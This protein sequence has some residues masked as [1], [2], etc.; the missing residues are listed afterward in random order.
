[1]SA[2]TLD[3]EWLKTDGLGGFASAAVSLPCSRRYHALLMRAGDRPSLLVNRLDAC[4]TTGGS[5]HAHQRAAVSAGSHRAR[6]RLARAIVHAQAMAGVDVGAAGRPDPASG[7]LRV[8]WADRDRASWTLSASAAEAT[9]AVGPF[10][11]V[12]IRLRLTTKTRSFSSCPHAPRTWWSGILTR[13]RRQSR[14]NPTEGA[15]KNFPATG[16]AAPRAD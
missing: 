10:F 13:V 4:V 7:N 6:R 16:T 12:A 3:P 11:P 8:S 14:S 2:P 15:L 9:L 1:M 5:R